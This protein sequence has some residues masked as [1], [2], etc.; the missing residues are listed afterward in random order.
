MQGFLF[1]RPVSAEHF[2]QLLM[3]E[4]VC[5]GPGGSSASPR[6]RLSAIA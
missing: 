1:S 4:A 6:T 3:L 2:E 5:P